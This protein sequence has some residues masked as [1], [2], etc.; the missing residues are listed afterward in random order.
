MEIIKVKCANPDCGLELEVPNSKNEAV[1]H[2][3]CP[4]CKHPNIAV[5]RQEEPQA[6]V[7]GNVTPPPSS[8]SSSA[9]QP[10]K[11]EPMAPIQE[12]Q[13]PQSST[14]S[15]SSETQY[16]GATQYEGSARGGSG[17][18]TLLGSSTISGKS[19]G[20]YQVGLVYEGHFFPLA[21][22]KHSIGRKAMTSAADVQ[23]PTSDKTMSR[24]HAC[25]TVVKVK[26]G[27]ITATF[28]NDQN[29]N[30][31]YID[32]HLIGDGDSIQLM[33]GQ[34]IKMGGVEVEYQEKMLDDL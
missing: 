10:S 26:H 22:G 9:P 17:S 6:A 14:P 32:G 12:G 20:V 1:R 7:Q 31:T 21:P 18:D 24:M 16:G 2:F 15:T 23:I 13:H 3:K 5:F 34:K 19:G 29:K 8:S 4:V 11:R 33:N 30:N 25:V 27:V 28:V